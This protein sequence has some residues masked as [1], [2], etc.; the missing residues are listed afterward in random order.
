MESPT[1]LAEPDKSVLIVV[2]GMHR[3]GTSAI[4]RAMEVMGAE[5]GDN[6]MPPVPGVNDKGFFEDLDVYSLNVDVMSAAGTDWHSLAPIELE[7]I[8]KPQ[9]DALQTR[10]IEILRGKCRGRIFA[11]KDPRIT[12]LLPFWQPVFDRIAVRVVYVVTIRNPI[13]VA[14]SLEKRDHFAREKSFLL[15]LAHMV[16]ALAATNDS[17]RALVD[18]DR[19]MASPRSELERISQLLE[20]PIDAQRFSDFQ[21]EFLDSQLQHSRFEAGDLDVVRSAPRQVS[22]LFQA[23]QTT[24]SVV[25]E[26]HAPIPEMVLA[27]SQRFLDDLE[28]ILRHEW[29][30]EQQHSQLSTETAGYRQRVEELQH[31][32][33]ESEAQTRESL[34]TTTRLYAQ[35]EQLHV[36][37]RQCRETIGSMADR[38]QSIQNDAVAAHNALEQATHIVSAMQRSTSWRLT[39]PLRAARKL[40]SSGRKY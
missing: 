7:K 27:E 11:L 32:L 20:L 31:A 24:A 3:S 30:L 14:L 4:T 9:L 38:M 23:M 36:E 18:Y 6:L 12:R 28:P 21:S 25:D 34:D 39:A 15:W 26:M 17:Q 19:V 5:F 8:E 40:I 10:A 29:R 35:A 1:K 37:I 16:P 33:H 13:S 22:S 2:L